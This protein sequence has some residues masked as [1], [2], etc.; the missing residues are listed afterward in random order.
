[1]KQESSPLK[2]YSNILCDKNKSN[3]YIYIFCPP[4][5]ITL[6]IPRSQEIKRSILLILREKNVLYQITISFKLKLFRIRY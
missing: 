2:Y 1:M 6:L 4:N 5:R 3:L